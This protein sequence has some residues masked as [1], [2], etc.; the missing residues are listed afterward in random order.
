MAGDGPATFDDPSLRDRAHALARQMLLRLDAGDTE[1][2]VLLRTHDAL[3]QRWLGQRHASFARA[4][5]SFDFELG[6]RILEGALLADR[7]S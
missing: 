5:E 1:V 4:V 7:S 6:H 3:L 2:L